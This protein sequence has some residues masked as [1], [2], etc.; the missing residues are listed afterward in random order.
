[1]MPRMPLL[2]RLTPLFLLSIA[3]L[4]AAPLARPEWNRVDVPPLKTSIYVGSVTLTTSPFHR[5]GDVFAATYTAQVFPWFFWSETGSIRIT[6]TDEDLTRL[7]RGERLEFAGE[8]LNH[9]GKPRRVTGHADFATADTGKIKVRIAVDDLELI[10]NGPYQLSTFTAQA[11][12][13]Q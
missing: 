5:T 10:F 1:M 11:S 6:I 7:A 3:T 4:S 13:A 12:S 2:S 9:K 8:A